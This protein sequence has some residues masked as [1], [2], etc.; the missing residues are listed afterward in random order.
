[1]SNVMQSLVRST[2][3]TIWLHCAVHS[4]CHSLARARIFNS[5]PCWNQA[6][7]S[8]AWC[9]S[10]CNDKCF[11]EWS[12]QNCYQKVVNRWALHLCKRAGH[13]KNWQNSTDLQRF[14][15]QFK[16]LA[17][18]AGL[19]S[20]TVIYEAVSRSRSCMPAI[21]CVAREVLSGCKMLCLFRFICDYNSRTTGANIMWKLI[22]TS[23]TNVLFS[24]GVF[25][26][27]WPT[28]P[29][30]GHPSNGPTFWPKYFY[31]TRLSHES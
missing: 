19:V 11:S 23:W 20:R 22:C 31:E 6:A 13:F 15:F 21:S 18:F 28:L 25:V 30:P 5:V 16:V 14:I 27:L 10:E 1:M 24:G 3:Q 8:P 26:F 17:A 2:R 7:K 12:K 9:N 29:G 4:T